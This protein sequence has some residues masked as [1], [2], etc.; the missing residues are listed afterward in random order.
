MRWN[1]LPPWWDGASESNYIDFKEMMKMVFLS[2][3]E[4]VG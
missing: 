1:F 3:S 2:I 4:F